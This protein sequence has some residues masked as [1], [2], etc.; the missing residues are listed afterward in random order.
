M[1]KVL[2]LLLLPWDCQA[3]RLAESEAA[4][5]YRQI[6]DLGYTLALKVDAERDEFDGAAEIRFGLRPEA[7]AGDVFLEFDSGLIRRLVVNGKSLSQDEVAAHYDGQRLRFK[8]AELKEAGNLL[9]VDYTRAYVNNGNGLGRFKD[10]ADG[11]VYL[12]NHFEAY[13][14]H[15]VFPCFDQPDLKA[16]VDLTVE[17]PADWEVVASAPVK[18]VVRQGP[19]SSWVFERTPKL[20]TYFLNLSA[21][22]FRIWSGRAG[23]VPLRVLARQSAA[24]FV[25]AEELLEVLRQ[26]VGFYAREFSRPYPYHGLDL[27]LVPNFAA[28]AMENMAVIV[29]NESLT[30]FRSPKP[31]SQHVRR[32]LLVTHETAHMWFGDLVTMKWW[33]DLWLNE[34]FADLMGYLA[35][36]EATEFKAESWPLF[37]SGS[38]AGAYLQDQ[39]AT[40]HP[41]EVEIADTD[42]ARSSF[43]GIT[44]GKGAASLRQL[45]YLLGGE[46]FGKGLDI[47]FQRFAYGNAT[48]RGFFDAL[49]EASGKD[50]KDWEREWLQTAGLDA[51]RPDWD[52]SGGRLKSLVLLQSA[53]AGLP[54]LREHRAE[55]ALL[56]WDPAHARLAM[57]RLAPV[58]YQ[59]AATVVRADAP[60]P[61]LV[62]G[63]HGDYDYVKNELDP[64]SLK[65]VR[66]SLSSVD[67]DFMR[68]MLWGSLYEM[69]RDA[70]LSPSDYFAAARRHL[71]AETGLLA[72]ESVIDHLSSEVL[73]YTPPERRPK[74]AA[75]VERF[76]KA[77][78]DASPPGSDRQ[79]LYMRG[80]LGVVGSAQGR[81][82]LRRLLAGEAFLPGFELM[83]ERRWQLIQALAR[84]G[85]PDA[86]ALIAAEMKRDATD[87]GRKEA[88]RAECLL[89]DAGTKRRW[90]SRITR[91]SS[92]PAENKFDAGDLKPALR[93]FQVLAQEDLLREFEAP[94]FEQLARLSDKEDRMYLQV[95][96]AGLY[97]LDCDERLVRATDDFLGKHPELFFGIR[98]A[99]LLKRQEAERC[100]RA[101][102]L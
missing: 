10:V 71:P 4:L 76:L 81:Q 43:D 6:A 5:R 93:V 3:A 72:I 22:P 35:G 100:L 28:G 27:V 94:Y 51:M 70:K 53:P 23:A 75:E 65:A 17:A 41:V 47:Y 21:G 96:A 101:R 61:A 15:A 86:A 34:S 90:F 33:N 66:E 69:L 11:R 62:F 37:Y 82:W 97:P 46:A 58:S 24:Q 55:L 38:K 31:R 48:A 68:L 32:A 26:T 13:Y 67:D 54:T 95:L 18:R 49:E 1:I 87:D 52:C 20:S 59:G 84:A 45:R 60:C 73:R 12:S 92:D 85:S 44:Y 2:I 74:L 9:E 89:P 99:L 39:T 19:R 8:A 77:Q 80:Y 7:G 57:E 14:A 56:R 36:A 42:Q 91:S 79:L 64:K 98:K 16:A 102:R 30:V 83:Q 40:T 63:N 25:E 29:A 78:L 88:Y 50:L